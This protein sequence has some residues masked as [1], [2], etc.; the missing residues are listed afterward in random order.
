M[1]TFDERKK[2]FEKK[3][4]HDSEVQFKVEAR[5][6]KLLGLWASDLL[7]KTEATNNV[8]L[9]NMTKDMFLIVTVPVILG[10]LFRKFVPNLS[11]KLEPTAKK[12]SIK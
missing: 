4:A 12:I 1:S 11:L 6:N 8:S 9:F 3:F 5:R 10:M 7:G 2:A